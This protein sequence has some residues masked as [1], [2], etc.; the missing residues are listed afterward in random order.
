MHIAQNLRKL[1]KG[2]NLDQKD[3]A[4]RTGL[5]LS[6]IRNLESEATGDV[7]INTVVKLCKFFEVRV[8]DFVHKEL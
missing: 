8:H 4:I 2:K 1:R 6:T 7:N 5:S 3:L